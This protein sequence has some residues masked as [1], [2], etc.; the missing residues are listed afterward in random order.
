MAM[1]DAQEQK[2]SRS[3]F[4]GSKSSEKGQNKMGEIAF[5]LEGAVDQVD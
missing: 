3:M 2:A 1:Q 4:K 5:F